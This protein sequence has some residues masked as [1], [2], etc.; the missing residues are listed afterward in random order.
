MPDEPTGGKT[1]FPHL[2]IV[3]WGVN[4]A[5]Y[6]RNFE[7]DE[8]GKENR[9]NRVGHS[10]NLAG[11]LLQ[12]ETNYR[13]RIAKRK[14][15]Q[16]PDIEN[17]I[18]FAIEVT[19]G[20]DIDDLVS[21]FKLELVADED[22]F[23]GSE[24]HRY[25]LVATEAI[26]QSE[27]EKKIRDF[28]TG[29]RGSGAVA[30]LVE[31][32]SDVADPRRIEL[33]L[34]EPLR[35]SWPFPPGEELTL[36]VSF[37]THG[38]VANLP[39]RPRKKPSQSKDAHDVLLKE[40][41]DAGRT[42]LNEQWDEFSMRLETEVHNIIAAYDGNMADQVENGEIKLQ[43]AKARFPD[44][45][46]MRIRMRGEGFTDLI[47]NHPRIF[48]VVETEA[49]ESVEIIADDSDEDPT[50]PPPPEIEPP[51]PDAPL[52]CIIDSGI[53]EEH[54]LLREAIAADRSICFLPGYGVDDTADEFPGGHGTR[55]AGAVLYPKAIPLTGALEAR[56]WIGNARVLDPY[57]A[58][59]ESVYPPA[60]LEQVFAH[61]SDCKI[62]VHSINVS[63]AARRSRMPAWSAKIDELCYRED[64]LFI[65]SAG[66]LPSRQPVPG[67]GFIDHLA[68]GSAHPN[69]LL[70]ASARIANPAHS[71]QALVVGSLAH[72]EFQN[73]SL[74]SISQPDHPSCFSRSGFGMWN[75]IK[76]D[77]VE[78]G[79]DACTQSHPPPVTALFPPD[80]CPHLVRSTL[81]GGPETGRDAAGTSYAAP[82]VAAL[83]AELQK[84]L[85][86]QSPLLYRAL[87]VNSARWPQWAEQEQDRDERTKIFKWLGYGQPDWSRA[88]HNDVSRVTLT[89]ENYLT[90]QAGQAVVL[91]VPIPEELRTPGAVRRLRI[92]VTLSAASEP[93]RARASLNG[94][95]AVWLDWVSSNLRE[96]LAQFTARMWTTAQM[97][98]D[99]V[100]TE[101][102]DWMLSD[103]GNT[104][105][106]ANVRRKGT[107]QKD[108]ATVS[109][110]DLPD[111]FALAVRGHRGWNA[112][113][114]D[115][116]AKFALAVSIEA[117]DP[118]VE[119]YE[120]VHV[121]LDELLV[122]AQATVNA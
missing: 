59:P 65:V 116:T 71:L 22:A 7:E 11:D 93:R 75:T 72:S 109:G 8:Q 18:P 35:Q 24:R 76:P 29:V 13:K 91:A 62:F 14:T 54:L 39:N 41:F 87:I 16:L 69:Y 25:V 105:G 10:A 94:Y 32:I 45:I 92:D 33:I 12:L 122:Q 28:A 38:I 27:L 74:A 42:H 84:L 4:P 17:G 34:S 6:D 98:D 108:W 85:P 53:Q 47:L 68:D 61:F 63:F 51:P 1:R 49:T 106:A 107:L 43:G 101:P 102:I 21:S 36:D 52:V 23:K 67:K 118:E 113:D 64:V 103:R 80:V 119:V 120:P 114:A 115:A 3:Y 40:W 83:A 78:L 88:S 110:F 60:L 77:V 5:K 70:S 97:P 30:G 99:P 112:G 57:L 100:G 44:S 79:G 31:I 82:K 50:P 86:D 89:T 26:K 95:Q 9:L 121:A 15:E 37:Q 46:S 90:L 2:E 96:P 117:Y 20:F 73:H 111:S 19:P 48:E 81:H 66:N 104:G 58:L 56:Y 55:V